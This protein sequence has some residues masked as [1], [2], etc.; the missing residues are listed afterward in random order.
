MCIRDSSKWQQFPGLFDLPRALAAQTL[1]EF[2]DA[3]TAPLHGF[4][5]VEDYWRRASAKPGLAALEL[6]TLMLNARNDPLVP[7]SSL[8]EPDE[9]GQGVTLWQP[10]TGGHVGFPGQIGWRSGQ[11]ELQLQAMPLAVCGWLTASGQQR[12]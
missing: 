1:R 6:P 11:P 9:V 12:P 10:G 3:F 8:P 5:G 2:D 7:A 4:A